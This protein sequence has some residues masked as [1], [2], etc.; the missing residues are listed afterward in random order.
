MLEYLKY[1]FKK[2]FS[3]KLGLTILILCIIYIVCVIIEVCQNPIKEA[4]Y[5]FN[6]DYYNL[7][8]F[9]SH[10]NGQLREMQSIVLKTRAHDVYEFFMG[11]SQ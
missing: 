1:L 8:E 4:L 3:S 7:I 6:N 5:L 9:I 2:Y 10:I 11:R